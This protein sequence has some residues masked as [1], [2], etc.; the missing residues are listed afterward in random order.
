MSRR[1]RGPIEGLVLAAG[2]GRRFGG[3]KQ[4]ALLDGRPLLE[5][6][7]RALAECARLDGVVVTLGADAER[8]A[9]AVDLHGARRALVVDWAEGVA[10]SLRTGLAALDPRAEAVVVV[11]GDQPGIT[12]EM[13]A[14]V[15][16]AAR[17]S[18]CPAVRA[19]HGGR[20]GHPVLL[21]RELFAPI[22]E[23]RG[24][25]GAAAVLAGVETMTVECGPRA[26]L[27]V[28]TAAD[29]ARERRSRASRR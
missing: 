22:R 23:L 1:P 18:D 5:H 19:T 13:V 15:V 7:T 20:P 4:L 29:L 12:A 17:A 9:R 26:V 16:D 6:A 3:V 24:D 14:R 28:D 25:V 8:I 10:A 2:A 11:L 21:R 27:D